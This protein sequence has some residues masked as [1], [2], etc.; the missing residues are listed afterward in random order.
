VAR[1]FLSSIFS[2]LSDPTILTTQE[3]GQIALGFPSEWLTALW[4]VKTRQTDLV[5]LP[6]RM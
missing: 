1:R 4:R 6:V 5:L 2:R 3:P